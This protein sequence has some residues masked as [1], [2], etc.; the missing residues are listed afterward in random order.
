MQ[1]FIVE[2]IDPQLNIIEIE[3]SYLDIINNIEIERSSDFNIEIVNTEKVLVSDLPDNIPLSKF[4]IDGPNDYNRNRP[5][6]ST[7]CDN[8]NYYLDNYPF[9]GGSP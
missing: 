9:D 5:L 6:I 7:N 3:T 1:N 2:I 8:L 4:K